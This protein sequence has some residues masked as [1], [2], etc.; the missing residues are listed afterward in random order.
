MRGS[1]R[2]LLPALVPALLLL[3]ACGRDGGTRPRANVLLV[4]I[5]TL[6]ADHLACYGYARP[7]SPNIDRLAREGTLFARAYAS[8]SWTIPSHMTMFTSLPPSLH[9]VDDVGKRLDP[10]RITLAERLRESGY[11]TAA[12]VSGPTM[13]AAFGFDHGF[14]RYEN[15]STF[16]HEDF[17]RG[18]ATRPTAATRHRSHQDVTSPV[19]AERVE[20]WIDADARP[21][22]FLFVHFWDPH[23]DYIPPPPYDTRFDPGWKGDFD[24]SN[25]EFNMAISPEMPT[26]AFK[27]L[28]SLYDGEIAFTDAA[29]GRLIAAL[30]QRGWLDGT[31]VALTA[32]HGEEFFDHG[33]KGHMT[34]L[35][36]EVLHVPLVF[37]LPGRVRAAR[38]SD[39]I[40]GAVHLMPT[41]LGIAGVSPGPEAVGKDLSAHLAGD[42]PPPGLWAFAELSLRRRFPLYAARIGDRKYLAEVTATSPLA[43][44]LSYFGLGSAPEEQH[45]RPAA[46][47]EGHAFEERLRAHV[48]ELATVRAALPR[49]KDGA[50]AEI[51]EETK[52]QLR[53]LG[54]VRD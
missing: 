24:F 26:R 9:G 23:Y 43:L 6:R 16:T 7:T 42:E 12:F 48:A 21:P 50:V 2:R 30:E 54:Y 4:S 38:R 45:P 3:G 29:V 34:T 18:D 39:A 1:M 40:V 33:G 37:R 10:A 27:H 11:Q 47:D 17:T 31:L 5:D 53:A 28:V 52:R 32:D 8:S 46:D 15:T 14:D 19:V 22:F 36:E 41:I 13:H 20:H 49:E 25:V 51:S 35:F 44:N